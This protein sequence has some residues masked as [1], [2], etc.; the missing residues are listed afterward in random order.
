[1]STRSALSLAR[2]QVV[3]ALTNVAGYQSFMST[4]LPA[5]TTALGVVKGEIDLDPDDPGDQAF[6]D[7]FEEFV[8]RLQDEVAAFPAQV[9]AL[10]SSIA[11]L[12][13]QLAELPSEPPAPAPPGER[14]R[15]VALVAVD[16]L[17]RGERDIV[18]R[19]QEWQPFGRAL[20][21][22]PPLAFPQHP[23]ANELVKLPSLAPVTSFRGGVFS[24][25]SVLRGEPPT[26][27][28]R[29][30]QGREADSVE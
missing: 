17:A 21:E 20:R 24:V 7:F 16:A 23:A 22:W 30:A 29:R 26:I 28:V 9:V 8:D 5:L 11:A 19:V 12:D 10:G 25:A 13:E 2:D 4:A 3:A 6:I 14:A 27:Y 18:V 15:A 1:M